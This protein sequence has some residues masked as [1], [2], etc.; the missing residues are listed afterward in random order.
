MGEKI[1]KGKCPECGAE[2][3]WSL[4]AGLDEPACPCGW[5]WLK[6][7]VAYVRRLCVAAGIDFDALSRRGM[8]LD[9]IEALIDGDPRR[10]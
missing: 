10:H 1:M 6:D 2:V 5:S 7:R 4:P 8:T 9:D 3:T